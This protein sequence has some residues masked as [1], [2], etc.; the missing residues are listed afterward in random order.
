M[1]KNCIIINTIKKII[2]KYGLETP[3]D[4][5]FKYFHCT[6]LE[7]ESKICSK[8][9]MEFAE[10][11]NYALKCE[12]NIHSGF[13]TIKE[14]KTQAA[15]VKKLKHPKSPFKALYHEDL[16]M[17][18][19][20]INTYILPSHI[21]YFKHDP[22]TMNF[23][24]E[25]DQVI[26][27]YY[28]KCSSVVI[29]VFNNRGGHN[30]AMVYVI[31]KIFGKE[32]RAEKSLGKQQLYWVIR[33]GIEYRVTKDIYEKTPIRDGKPVII[34]FNDKSTSAGEFCVLP[35]YKAKN[36]LFISDSD[37]SAG[38]TT[39][40][41]YFFITEDGKYYKDYVSNAKY[42]LNLTIAHSTD[43]KGHKLEDD[44]I[45]PDIKC[46]YPLKKAFQ[47]ADQIKKSGIGKIP[48]FK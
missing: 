40:N 20:K 1:C 45:R 44:A 38:Y 3:A 37:Q 23:I 46:K 15:Q 29:D 31:R 48:K 34:L 39:D 43:I 28:N 6:T 25:T 5:F 18:Y 9:E 36:T 16:N 21:D 26:N 14:D 47:I 13:W 10:L 8:K 30:P 7:N 41:I 11:V 12:Y 22:I 2:K 33:N 35:L 24:K 4:D 19:I 32:C 27:K 17:L 42:T